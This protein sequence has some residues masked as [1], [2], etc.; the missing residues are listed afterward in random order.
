MYIKYIILQFSSK[1]MLV[2]AA[3]HYITPQKSFPSGITWG[4]IFI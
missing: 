4:I 3:E 2:A 1:S